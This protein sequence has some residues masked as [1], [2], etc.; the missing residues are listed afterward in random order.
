MHLICAFLLPL[1]AC[2]CPREK[3]VLLS[4]P[5]LYALLNVGACSAGRSST[6]ARLLRLIFAAP[7]LERAEACNAARRCTKAWLF[8]AP[9]LAAIRCAVALLACYRS[10]QRDRSKKAVSPAL[11]HAA[12]RTRTWWP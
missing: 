1:Y 2:C 8:H 3:G 12:S 10:M 7:A 6:K 5:V 11:I 4:L 9:L